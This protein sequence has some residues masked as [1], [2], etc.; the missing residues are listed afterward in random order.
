L[1]IELFAV[2]RQR[3][4]AQKITVTLPEGATVG[5]LL[6]YLP[7]SYPDLAPLL[8]SV[9]VAVNMSYATA[10]DVLGEKDQIAL[11]PPVSGG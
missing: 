11:I 2:L 8:S 6:A 4:S 5:Q 3:L 1:T 7:K 9:S 10:D